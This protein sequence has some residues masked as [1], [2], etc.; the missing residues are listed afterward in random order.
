M[1]R[2]GDNDNPLD[3]SHT[4]EWQNEHAAS[5][6]P[7]DRGSDPARVSGAYEQ[8]REYAEQ[9]NES[10][11]RKDLEDKEAGYASMADA[12]TYARHTKSERTTRDGK[13]DEKV[14][15]SF[16]PEEGKYPNTP[17]GPALGGKH[18]KSW[19]GRD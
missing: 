3:F 17:E 14:T 2:G 8:A 11:I 4:S 18:G 1:S 16:K 12:T 5:Q 6:T 10:D 7:P 13:F 19:N 9:M 15:M